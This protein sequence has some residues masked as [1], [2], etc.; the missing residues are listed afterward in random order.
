MGARK[1]FGGFFVHPKVPNRSWSFQHLPWNQLGPVLFHAKNTNARFCRSQ[2]GL[3]PAIGYQYFRLGD[4][5]FC[6][7]RDTNTCPLP[8]PSVSEVGRINCWNFLQTVAKDFSIRIDFIDLQY[9]AHF[10]KKIDVSSI[11]MDGTPSNAIVHLNQCLA[12]CIGEPSGGRRY[13]GYLERRGWSV[14]QGNAL[15]IHEVGPDTTL[16]R[17]ISCQQ[18]F[19]IWT[20]TR[21]MNRWT[22][23]RKFGCPSSRLHFGC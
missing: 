5:Q 8:T 21:M 13:K 6:W 3:H 19:S 11:W 20:V 10:E 4:V 22:N 15:F 17:R 9:R 12:Q 1:Y 23:G 18:E 14:V 7:S 16:F 2:A